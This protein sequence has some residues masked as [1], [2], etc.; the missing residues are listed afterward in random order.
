MGYTRVSTKKRCQK[1]MQQ[2]PSAAFAKPV[3]MPD[4]FAEVLKD[5]TRE[6]LRQQ[7]DNLVDFAVKYF[8]RKCNGVAAGMESD[9]MGLEEIEGVVQALFQR[10]DA[11]NSGFLDRTEFRNLLN[12]LREKV[13]F[14]T[15]KDLLF[16]MSE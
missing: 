13:P 9:E 1:I 4:V 5:F 12:D 6:C 11:D 2:N 14:I 16:F 15:E 10:Y 8:D 7:P 3:V